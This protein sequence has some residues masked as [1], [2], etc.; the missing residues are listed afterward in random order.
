MHCSLLLRHRGEPGGGAALAGK[1]NPT[2]TEDKGH[3]N[4]AKRS[5]LSLGVVT[6]GVHLVEIQ[7]AGHLGY[8][9]FLAFKEH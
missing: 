5:L 9:V 6:H 1:R 2:E 8:V 7:P 4:P 3:Q